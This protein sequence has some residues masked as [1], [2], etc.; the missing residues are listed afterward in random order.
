MSKHFQFQVVIPFCL[1]GTG[2]F[3]GM[4]SLHKICKYKL[5]LNR[6]I[7]NLYKNIVKEIQNK[8]EQM[9]LG[10]AA[11][12]QKATDLRSSLDLVIKVIF[13]MYIEADLFSI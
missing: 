11:L 3:L 1:L 4:F 9:T 6:S 7:F 13:R 12:F 8:Q 10:A 2:E 5:T